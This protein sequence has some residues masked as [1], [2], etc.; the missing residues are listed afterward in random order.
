MFVSFLTSGIKS[1]TIHATYVPVE[2]L[3]SPAS[4]TIL[5]YGRIKLTGKFKNFKKTAPPN[6]IT[7]KIF[8]PE[9]IN[10]YRFYWP[11]SRITLPQ[12]VMLKSWE[13]RNFIFN[14]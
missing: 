4:A 3:K 14:E 5:V 11:F 12:D 2:Y 9:L 8:S 7:Y 10:F 6:N 13:Y 1:L